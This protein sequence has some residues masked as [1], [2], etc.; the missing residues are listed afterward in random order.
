MYYEWQI[1]MKILPIG[2]I[3]CKDIKDINENLYYT[4][5]QNWLNWQGFG[6]DQFIKKTF[7]K[8]GKY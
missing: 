2:Y 3:Q 4:I 7:I 1:F 8:I 6:Y 5:Y